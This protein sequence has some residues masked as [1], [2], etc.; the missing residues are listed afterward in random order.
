MTGQTTLEQTETV[1]L[2]SR[3]LSQQGFDKSS[4]IFL[5]MQTVHFENRLRVS[6]TRISFCSTPLAHHKPYLRVRA[7]LLHSNDT[8]PASVGFLQR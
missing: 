7:L 8:C 4:L 1:L 5:E 2:T 3:I 6:Y